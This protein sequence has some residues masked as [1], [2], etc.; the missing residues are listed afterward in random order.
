M[1]FLKNLFGKP[2]AS[3][4][5]KHLASYC[6]S[7]LQEA[8]FGYE[9]RLQNLYQKILKQGDVA[10]DVGAHSGRHTIPMAASVG[11]K[12]KVIAFEVLPGVIPVLKS[13]CDEFALTTVEIKDVALSSAPGAGSFTVALDRLQESGLLRRD[14]YNGATETEEIQVTIETLDHY[15]FGKVRFIKIDTEG[16]E[17][18]VLKGAEQTLRDHKPVIAFEFGEN[19]YKPYGVNPIEVFEYLEGLGYAVLS[20]LGETLTKEG[21]Q[22]ASVE[23]R[24]WDY[25]ACSSKDLAKVQRILTSYTPV[26]A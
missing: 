13:K 3:P 2:E 20:I 18:D 26:T 17:F 1:K 22:R 10:V 6:E 5:Q 12:G 19:S 7:L 21:F 23:Q 15:D 4:E 8:D 16:A 24:Y 11:G 25:V 9:E 14:V